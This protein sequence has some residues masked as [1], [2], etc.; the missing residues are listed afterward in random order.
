MAI[1]IIRLIMCL[2]FETF[3]HLITG[4]RLSIETVTRDYKT[5]EKWTGVSRCAT[6]QTTNGAK[7]NITNV[8]SLPDSEGE[9]GSGQETPSQDCNI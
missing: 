8:I 7:H 9:A 3:L 4:S 5:R 2:N 6:C 1:L